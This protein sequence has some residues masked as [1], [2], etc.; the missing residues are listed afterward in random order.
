[1]LT[2]E[3]RLFIH[4]SIQAGVDPHAAD[5][6]GKLAISSAGL[7]RRNK[8]VYELTA[9]YG[10]RLVV[11]MGGGYPKDLDMSSEPFRVVMQSHMDVYRQLC[12]RGPPTTKFR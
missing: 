11:T 5:R 2:L 6:F 8:L 1:M 12:R 10:S 9:A 4:S 3:W 7:K